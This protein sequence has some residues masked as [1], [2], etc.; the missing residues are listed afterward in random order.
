MRTSRQGNQVAV[1]FM[2]LDGFEI[3]ND[4]LGHEEGI[5]Y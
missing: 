4:S 5:S 3:V 1:L 2:D